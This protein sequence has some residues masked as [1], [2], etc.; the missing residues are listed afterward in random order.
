MRALLVLLA[1]VI[2]AVALTAQSVAQTHPDQTVIRTTTRLVTVNVVVR[3]KNGPVPDLG[4]GDF[5]VFDR[6]KRQTIS[7]FTVDTSGTTIPGQPPIAE[8]NLF[9]NVL[10]RRANTPSNITVVLLDG[11]NTRL[12]DQQYARG[13]IEKFLASMRPQ[14]RVAIY[15]LGRTLT[16]LRDFTG[17]PGQ[18]Q[19]A[20]STYDGRIDS[21]AESMVPPMVVPTGN[22][23][24]TQVLKMMIE[25]AERNMKPLYYADSARRTAAAL[26]A[27][28]NHIA[29]LPGRKNLVWISASFPFWI[30]P[31][32]NESTLARAR[33][34][35]FGGIEYTPQLTHSGG[36][37]RN[38]NREIEGAARALNNAGMAIYPVDAR[39]LVALA[40]RY[41]AR[42]EITGTDAMVDR[43][44]LG[45][46][47]E[48]QETMRQLASRTG[49]KAFLNTNDLASAVREAID[50]SAVTYTLGFYPKADAQDGQYHDLRVEVPKRRGLSVRSRRGY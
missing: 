47:P 6:G 11:L 10:E 22:Y 45:A 43:N 40:D 14:D 5:A 36:E 1:I 48:G 13:Q 23:G 34:T 17:D 24:L 21:N 50:D 35:P 30:G 28:A 16:I 27:I 39:G 38:F 4:K 7:L 20:L 37:G 9:T 19:L 41:Q 33:R 32:T 31:K 49:G 2:S 12:K 15:T 42:S 18:L 46:R 29:P 44:P 3:D 25:N 26:E 8:P